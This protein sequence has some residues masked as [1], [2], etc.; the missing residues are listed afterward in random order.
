MAQNTSLFDEINK[1]LNETK[2]DDDVDQKWHLRNEKLKTK[3]SIEEV[4]S[5]YVDEEENIRKSQ[6][7]KLFHNRR[8]QQNILKVET[9]TSLRNKLTI[10][11]DLYEKCNELRPHVNIF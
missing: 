11:L 2:Q 4:R 5:D 9:T 10:P 7:D 8:I 6:R 3:S 1:K